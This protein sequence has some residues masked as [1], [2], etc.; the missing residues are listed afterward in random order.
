MPL[1]E[2]VL[3]GIVQGITEFLPVSSDGHLVITQTLLGVGDQ[4][5]VFVVAMHVGSLLA[6]LVFYRARVIELVE[7]AGVWF[8]AHAWSSAIV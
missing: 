8:N 1:W 5:L 6:L 2:A 4:G 3:L 7:E